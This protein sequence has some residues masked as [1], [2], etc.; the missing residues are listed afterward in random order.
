MKEQLYKSLWWVEGRGRELEL[1]VTYCHNLGQP[2]PSMQ[3]Y[4]NQIRRN[5]EDNLNIC[6]YGRRPT[7]FKWKITSMFWYMEENLFFLQKED[8]LTI[9]FK[10]S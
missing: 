8:N 1:V 10:G 6:F 2:I 5:M 4:F 7:F 9:L 3:H